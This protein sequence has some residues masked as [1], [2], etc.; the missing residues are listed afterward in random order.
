M[1]HSVAE[2]SEE[3]L[4]AAQGAVPDSKAWYEKFGD[5]IGDSYKRGSERNPGAVAQTPGKGSVLDMLYR[6]GQDFSDQLVTGGVN[7]LL[8]TPQGKKI[9]DQA[10]SNYFKRLM[11]N[12]LLIVGVVIVGLLILRGFKK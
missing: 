1:T 9:T 3:A 2:N 7:K 4:G 11:A 5:F 12:P 6:A 8:D 10:E